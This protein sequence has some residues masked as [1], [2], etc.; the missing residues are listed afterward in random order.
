MRMHA[1]AGQASMDVA[2]MCDTRMIFAVSDDGLSHIDE[3]FTNW[4]DC[5]PA[6]TTVINNGYKLA[7]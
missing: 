5:Y 1:G 3:E 4:D 7:K 2:E 6:A